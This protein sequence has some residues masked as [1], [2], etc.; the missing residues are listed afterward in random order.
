MRH[1]FVLLIGVVCIAGTAAADVLSWEDCVQEASQKNPDLRA[2]QENLRS[3]EFLAHAAMSGYFPQITASLS[4]SREHV[5]GLS[6]S[7]LGTTSRGT[8]SNSY[9]ASITGSQN[10][11]SGFQDWAKWHQAEANA[12]A[13]QANLDT[14]RAKVSYDLKSAFAGLLYAQ[15]SLEL[16]KNIIQRRE[17]NFNLVE[18]RF[19]SGNENKGSLLLSRAYLND[20]KLGALQAE[21]AIRVAQSQLARILGRDRHDD[22][23]VDGAVPVSLPPKDPAIVELVQ[24]TPDHRQAKAIEK[25]AEGSV[26]LA[27]GPFLP[28]LAL[29]GS[30]GRQGD[31]FFPT[32]DAWSVGVT[33]SYPLFSGG[34]DYYFTRSALEVLAAASS[35]RASVDNEV[36]TRLTQALTGFIEAVERLKVDKSYLEA[37]T[38]REE[39]GRSKYNNGLLSFENWDIIENDLIARQKN[40]L[41]S[42]RDRIVS[43]ASWEQA[44]GTGAIP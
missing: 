20:A 18:L 37:A 31:T 4:A 15:H 12:Q 44:L 41:Q 30:I 2:A 5:S 34:R 21:D 8:S 33:L 39:I 26:T 43:E 25:S 14:V 9:S 16:A 24:R 23:R 36:R 22:L 7:S 13:S 42:T 28:S 38:A 29:V 11:F 19:Q 35:S 6:E 10:L 17:E 27:R 1:L 3:S 32:T 40:V